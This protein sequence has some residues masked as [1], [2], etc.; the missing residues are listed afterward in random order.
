[1]LKLNGR[2]MPGSDSVTESLSVYVLATVVNTV[3]EIQCEQ[4]VHAVNFLI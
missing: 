1:M 4:T 2:W 3:P